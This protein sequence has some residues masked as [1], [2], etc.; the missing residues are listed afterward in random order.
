VKC[1]ISKSCEP[2]F[3]VWSEIGGALQTSLFS[4]DDEEIE[5]DE[6]YLAEKR[7]AL[8]GNSF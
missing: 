6:K 5:P 8:L 4:F 7:T 3:R 2:V 1:F